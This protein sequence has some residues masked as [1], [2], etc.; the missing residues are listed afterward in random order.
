MKNWNRVIE[1]CLLFVLILFLIVDLIRM[2]VLKSFNFQEIL[3]FEL[4]LLLTYM[5]YVDLERQFETSESC[6][7]S[8]TWKGVVS[9]DIHVY[10]DDKEKDL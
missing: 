10:E 8:E 9:I 7:A 2:I 3:L 4:M 1:M 6:E 5:I